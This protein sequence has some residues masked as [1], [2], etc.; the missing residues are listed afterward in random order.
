MIWTLWG[1]GSII[2]YRF[3]IKLLQK[4][5][6]NQR[7][8][9]DSPKTHQ[10]KQGTPTMGGVFIFG[11]FLI[12]ALLLNKWNLTTLWVVATTGL[13]CLI[14]GIDDVLALRK[15]KN[16]GLS[17]K[18][19]FILQIT[20][21]VAMVGIFYQWIKPIHWLEG[22]LYVFLLTG[23]SNATNLTDGVDGLLGS[24]M[25]VSLT[26]M[27]VIL[28]KQWMVEE[29]HL[30]YVMMA[31]IGFFLLFNWHPAK[32]FM[33]DVGS[34]MLGGFLAALAIASSAWWVLIGFGAI[35]II[36]TLSVMIQVVSYKIR[37]KRVFLMTPLHHHF[38]LLGMNDISVVLLF[39]LI[40]AGFTFIQLQ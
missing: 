7:I 12:G 25:L 19:K 27:L 26:G 40:Q 28:Q 33:G 2:S 24:T 14:G 31:A 23:T 21:S 35:Y 6:W 10:K 3:G 37:K 39:A 22:A 5:A 17:A 34:L 18:A 30:T 20:V 32:L 36:E 9:E 8:Y 15:G 13:F 11:S 1:F 38:E 16:K 4:R 29:L